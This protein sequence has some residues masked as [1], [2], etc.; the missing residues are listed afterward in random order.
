MEASRLSMSDLE[1]QKHGVGHTLAS[2]RAPA[3]QR[4]NAPED[5][6][7]DAIVV[8]NAGSSSLKFSIYQLRDDGEDVAIVARG[9]IEGLGTKP[10]FKVKDRTGATL[11]DTPV[12]ARAT[13]AGHIEALA[14]LVQWM[15]GAFA[16]VL[17]LKAVGH[18]VVHGGLEF[19]KPTLLTNEIIEKLDR[20]VPL[21]PLH[22]PYNLAAIRA[23]SSLRP[24]MPQ[25]ACFDT[26]FHR[27]RARVTER[28]GLPDELHRRG[29]R[30]WGFHGLSYASIVDQ[31]RQSAPELA[32]GRIIVAHLGNGASM[33]AIR[34]GQSVDTTMSFTTLDG[35]PMGTRC[36]GLDPG[37]V[38]YLLQSRS[39]QE[40]EELLYK[41]S[42]L[43]GISGIS[44]DMRELLASESAGAAEAINFFVYRAMR[45]IGSLTAALGGLDALVFTAGIGENSPVLRKRICLP[46]G[47]LGLAVDDAANDRGRGCISPAGRS[48]SVWVIPS[49][50]ERVIAAAT[51]DLVLA[52]AKASRRPAS[53]AVQ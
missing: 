4:V 52:S 23:V 48:P 10:H 14:H 33:C 11:V 7:S 26:A 35:L 3:G 46:L 8:L 5:A 38:L 39:Q 12:T 24:E 50:E 49:D 6:M 17:S 37:V 27:G 31:L 21:A 43:L 20:L 16:G 40:V 2:A 34:G 13:R 44:N 25:V 42:G 45:E 32:D 47:W 15:R 30:R 28:F 51:W 29:I 41:E 9:Q 53:L 22:Q 1:L 18:R 19:S 36:G